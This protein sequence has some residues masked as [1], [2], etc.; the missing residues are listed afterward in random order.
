[1]IKASYDIVDI[2]LF[3][4]MNVRLTYLDP[5]GSMPIEVFDFHPT[6]AHGI[7]QRP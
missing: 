4:C 3:S 1:M 5:V 6:P 7:H 2:A